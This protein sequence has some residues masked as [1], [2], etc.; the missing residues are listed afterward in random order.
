MASGPKKHPPENNNTDKCVILMMKKASRQPVTINIS[1]MMKSPVTIGKQKSSVKDTSS[2]RIPDKKN[3]RAFSVGIAGLLLLLF[4]LSSASVQGQLKTYLVLETGPAWD[5]SRVQG[6]DGLFSRSVVYGS[7]G[8]FSLWQ[9]VL[10]NL[11]IGTGL[12]A[13]QYAGGLNPADARPHQPSA[14]SHGT[15]L[16]PLRVSYRL[17]P[18][19][20]PVSLTARLGYEFGFLTGDPVTREAA[21]LVT[22]PEGITVQY[23]LTDELPFQNVL[24][25]VEAGIS[26]D[27]RF[28]NN[29]QVAVHLSQYTGLREIRHTT[30]DYITSAGN[31][32][33]AAYGH[34]GTRTQVT[35]N[36]GIPVSNLW[37]NRDVRLH[38]KVENSLGR[39]G[40]ARSNRYI[41]FGGDLGALWRAFSTSNPAIGARSMESPG[42]F[43]YANLR[44]GIYAGYMFNKTAGIDIGAYY[45]RSSLFISIM[46]DHETDFTA[47]ASSPMFLDVP[48]MLRYYIDL[49]KSKLF[50]VPSVGGAVLTHFSGPGYAT[51]N[52]AF[53]YQSIPGISD[54]TA[55]YVA[56]RPVRFGYA[57]R[58]SLGIEYDIPTPFPLLLTWNMTF[59]HG[60]RDLDVTEVT[61]SLDEIPAAA[62]VT[63]NGTGWMTSIGVRLP[64]SLDKDS[65]KCGAMPRMRR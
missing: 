51:G 42:I 32:A 27:Y 40:I 49:H 30:V 64:F 9:E 6:G 39:G 53:T 14:I 20:I 8:G 37:E 7:T 15:L 54:G 38:R 22:S 60:L 46:Y 28:S 48:V 11:S 45:Q 13:H 34:D 65:R 59:S 35:L 24:H 12:H 29:W 63:Y 55:S 19:G 17:Q 58:A 62:T 2:P 3:A 47:T 52:A 26:A 23:T 61:T 31:S 41:Y 10:P 25:M 56:G 5:V 33:Q 1:S 43:R 50:L 36:L 16:V 21:S 4:M 57:A 18:A 44:T